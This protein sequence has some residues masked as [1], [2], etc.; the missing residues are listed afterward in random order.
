MIIK[1]IYHPWEKWE[2]YKAGF[3]DN[4]SAKDKQKMINKVIEMFSSHELTEKY[5][6]KVINEWFFSCEHNLTNNGLNKIAYIGQ[7]ACCLYGKVPN[8]LTMYVWKHLSEKIKLRSDNIAKKT[9][10]KWEQ[11]KILEI[12]SK[13]GKKEVI[14]TGYQMKLQLN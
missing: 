1:R 14:N 7:A 10:S 9:I 8:L 3:Y 12:I 6:N 2:D 4:V 11:K 5:M 13:I